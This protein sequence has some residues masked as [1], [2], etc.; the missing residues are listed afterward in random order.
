VRPHA[1]TVC[2]KSGHDART[3]PTLGPRERRDRARR[4]RGGTPGELRDFLDALREALG[5]R[6]LERHIEGGNAGERQRE[7][8]ELAELRRFHVPE[9]HEGGG[10]TPMRGSGA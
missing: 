5:K 2:R 8:R 4:L 9:Y 10:R 3:C 6:P 1:C 7:R